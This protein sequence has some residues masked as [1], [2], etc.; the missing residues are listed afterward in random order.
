MQPAHGAASQWTEPAAAAAR[1]S[2]ARLVRRG[3]L[4]V[5]STS[6]P[7]D[8]ALADDGAGLLRV[9]DDVERGRRVAATALGR[10]RIL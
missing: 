2:Q 1:L 5:F 10:L 3:E 9:D 6:E 8:A 4:Y 7:A